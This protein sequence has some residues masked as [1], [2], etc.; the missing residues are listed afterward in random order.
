M[1]FY[2]DEKVFEQHPQLKVGIILIKNF[3]N[4]RRNS[5]VESLLRGTCAQKAKIFA[6]QELDSI[7]EIKYWNE[8]YVHFGVNPK[9]YTPQIKALARKIIQRKEVEHIN[10][11]LDISNYFAI[12]N[13][14]PVHAH[15]LDWL[16]GDLRLTYAKGVEAFRA[17][18]TI[19]V[20]DAKEGEIAY[21]DDGGITN[22]Y[23]NH[24]ECER[25]K[26]TNKTVN[27]VMI[28]EDL[29]DMHMDKFGEILR[30]MQNSVIKYI[31]GQIEPYIISKGSPA[32]EMGI[33]GR[34]SADD[35]KIPQQEIAY[36]LENHK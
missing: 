2:I 29:S 32:I 36:F 28:V 3:D 26:I 1:K 11:L 5:S 18:N 10:T 22:R 8:A 9:K 6:N 4:M 13:L 20:K 7:D 27:A 34:R 24:M 31:G 23:W 35:S 14:I 17:I 12:K 19:E 15:D 21:M 30:E 33:E 25:T 16:C